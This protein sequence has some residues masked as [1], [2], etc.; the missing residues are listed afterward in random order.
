VL[1]KLVLYAETAPLTQLHI[2]SLQTHTGH[3]HVCIV[4]LTKTCLREKQCC[5]V[6]PV[7]QPPCHSTHSLS[8][9]T[10][11]AAHLIALLTL[12]HTVLHCSSV[13]PQLHTAARVLHACTLH[14][15][16]HTLPCVTCAC[17]NMCYAFLPEP[18]LLLRRCCISCR[19]CCALLLCCCCC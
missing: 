17:V 5:S 8:Y 6:L 14:A 12:H 1:H 11:A 16:T 9:T 18:A 2:P 4:M 7:P 13:I 19:C 15:T 3:L 10:A